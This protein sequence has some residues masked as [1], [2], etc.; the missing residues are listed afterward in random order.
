[1]S[2]E[3][4]PVAEAGIDLPSHYA[5]QRARLY[6]SI[7]LIYGNRDVAVEATDNAYVRWNKR[8]S[9]GTR[10]GA[11][12]H[13]FAAASKFA[14]RRL[15]NPNQMVQGFRL[16]GSEVAEGD[17]HLL[18]AFDRL[19]TRDRAFLVADAFWAWDADTT[20]KALGVP[21][22]EVSPR[23]DAAWTR[24]ARATGTER[25]E[26][27]ATLTAALAARADALPEPLGRL[28]S[29]KTKAKMRT[30]GIGVGATLAGVALATGT[31][32]GVSQL[33]DSDD[34]AVAAGNGTAA[35]TSVGN[36]APSATGGTTNVAASG[37]ATASELLWEPVEIPIRQGE[38]SSVAYGTA[39]FVGVGMD[40]TGRSQSLTL[41]S[42]DG[43]TWEVGPGPLEGEDGWIA[44][45]I[46]VGDM[47]VAIGSTFQGVQRPLVATSTDG[48]E[49]LRSDLPVD[50]QVE[51]GGQSVDV[52]TDVQGVTSRGDTLIVLGM[53][54][55]EFDPMRLLEDQL[56]DDVNL[57]GGWGWG[58]QGIEIYNNATGQLERRISWDDL[59]VDAELVTFITSG[60]PLLWSSDD[61]TTWEVQPIAGF[62]PGSWVQTIVGNEAAL[63]AVVGGQFGQA[64]WVSTDDGTTWERLDIGERGTTVSSAA[65][66]NGR[67]LAAGTDATGRGAVWTS[68]DGTEWVQSD[69]PETDI[70]YIERIFTGPAGAVLLGQDNQGG[71]AGPAEILVDDLT[72]EVSQNNAFT[73]LDAAGE[74]LATIYAEEAVYEDDGSITLNDPDTGDH[75]ATITQD[76]LNRAWEAVWIGFEEGPI[77]EFGPRYTVLLSAD[78]DAWSVFD[79]EEVGGFYPNAA[80]LGP[81]ALVMTGWSDDGGFEGGGTAVWVATAS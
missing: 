10:S 5:S 6:Q 59:D 7:V 31:W 20:G 24:L 71:I 77:A 69:L 41:L 27:S 56:P 8:R 48:L 30:V 54:H 58:P 1:M 42:E 14:N 62:G 12:A 47:Y 64:L 72:I 22:G 33:L 11:D 80:A 73:V 45:T 16:P 52:Y 44:Q 13:L 74:E 38:V 2:V 9:G 15:K 25:A 66:L 21:A 28:D 61:L 79:M 81:D 36:G 32:L 43:T 26:I 57:N 39:G 40:W 37:L 78:G 67:L 4:P 17:E 46:A 68:T 65:V 23:I 51:I 50:P 53:Q 63:V 3:T 18:A 35:G 19:E 34:P 29:V 55:A 75:L 76:E 70:G 49:W 60:R